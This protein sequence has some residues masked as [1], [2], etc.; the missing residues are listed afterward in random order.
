MLSEGRGRGVRL[1]V[2]EVFLTDYPHTPAAPQEGYSQRISDPRLSSFSLRHC[3]CCYYVCIL[4]IHTGSLALLAQV[5][6]H[7]ILLQQWS[8]DARRRKKGRCIHSLSI[9]HGSS[10]SPVNR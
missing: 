9:V 1:C 4:V 5:T 2:F 10:V 7:T 8:M 3:C 6:A